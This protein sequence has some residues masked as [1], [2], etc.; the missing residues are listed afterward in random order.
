MEQGVILDEST[1][2]LAMTV[3][4]QIK[5]SLDVI[6]QLGKMDYEDMIAELNYGK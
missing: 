1:A 6:T 2:W 4:A 5:G 3:H